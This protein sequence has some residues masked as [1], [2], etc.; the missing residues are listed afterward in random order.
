M[1]KHVDS[2]TKNSLFS[3]SIWEFYNTGSDTFS[4]AKWL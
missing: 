3:C 1:E 2:L 4:P